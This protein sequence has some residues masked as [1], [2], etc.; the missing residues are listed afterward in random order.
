MNLIIVE[1]PTKART[2]SRFLGKNNKVL[3]TKG[4]VRD[5]PKSRLGVDLETFEPEYINI[6]G[7]AP[8]INEIK[9]AAKKSDKVYIATDNDREGEA[10]AWHVAY[11]LGL[12]GEKNRIEFNEITKKINFKSNGR[13]KDHR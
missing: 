13:P 12:E 5:L 10:I 6:R 2:I 1:S 3:A 7:K 8:V 4:H 9:S 11:L